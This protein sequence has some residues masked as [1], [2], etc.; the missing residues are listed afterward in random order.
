MQREGEESGGHL[1][2]FLEN[3]HHCFY[4]FSLFSYCIFICFCMIARLIYIF[5]FEI[6]YLMGKCF[7]GTQ[8][9]LVLGLFLWH[10]CGLRFFLLSAELRC[11]L[12]SFKLYLFVHVTV[13]T[14]SSHP[15][16]MPFPSR[17]FLFLTLP[18]YYVILQDVA[19]CKNNSSW[20]KHVFVQYVTVW[21]R[22]GSWE[23]RF[24]VFA[25]GTVSHGASQSQV[26][27][28]R[29][30]SYSWLGQMKSQ[31]EVRHAF[32]HY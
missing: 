17:Y 22:E 14:S 6:R 15:D 27:M 32:A 29:S 18:S 12:V 28:E 26:V 30:C 7:F 25:W 4:S 8:E 20:K 31:A 10:H 5:T 11:F 21:T 3:S 2:A 19:L 1:N 16:G 13:W 23:C 24:F 9:V